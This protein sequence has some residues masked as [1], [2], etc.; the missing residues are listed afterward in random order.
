M[1]TNLGV[2]VSTVQNQP[3]IDAQVASALKDVKLKAEQI[4]ASQANTTI[5]QAQ[6]A[7]DLLVKAEQIANMTSE[8]DLRTTQKSE[9]ILDGVAKR[10]E[11]K[12]QTDLLGKQQLDITEATAL[13]AEEIRASQADT[14]R[15]GAQS[16]K[17]LSVKGAQIAMIDNQAATELKKALL[18][19]RQTAVYDD[20]LRIEK[21][22]QMANMT[23]MFGAG[24]NASITA[25][26][27]TDTFNA[28]NAV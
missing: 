26:Q 4:A 7:K 1:E 16:A 2:S 23:G 25:Q 27:V 11:I 10:A 5:A 22:K 20:N 24:G 17:D 8:I 12:A 18:T 3:L 9:A 21:A 28:I 6:N 15:K 14:A 13:K 19:V